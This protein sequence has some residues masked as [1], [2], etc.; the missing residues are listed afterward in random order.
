MPPLLEDCSI[1]KEMERTEEDIKACYKRVE[2]LE[3]RLAETSVSEEVAKTIKTE[4][5]EVRKLLGLNEQRLAQ[6]RKAN[7]KSFLFVLALC[8]VIFAIYMIY[9]LIVGDEF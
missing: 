6:L 4:L 1:M 5:N 8:F 2:E 7:R 3:K 9:I